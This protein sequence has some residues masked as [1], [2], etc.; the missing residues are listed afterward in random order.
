MLSW[1]EYHSPYAV[2]LVSLSWKACVALTDREVVQRSIAV[3]LPPLFQKSGTPSLLAS[4]SRV[5]LG[6]KLPGRSPAW[7]SGGAGTS[8]SIAVKRQRNRRRER[9]DR[10]MV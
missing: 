7:R 4:V 1:S 5:G 8:E 2:V 6:Q 9:N 3:L 10:N